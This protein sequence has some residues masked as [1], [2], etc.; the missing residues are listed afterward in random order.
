MGNGQAQGPVPT[1]DILF[2]DLME[3]SDISGYRSVKVTTAINGIE[4][5]FDG[6]LLLG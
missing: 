4:N 3:Q 6:L 2:P 5:Y 1:A